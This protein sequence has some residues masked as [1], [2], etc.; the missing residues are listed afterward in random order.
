MRPEVHRKYAL[1][2]RRVKMRRLLHFGGLVVSK[3]EVLRTT[4]E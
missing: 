3:T 4:E 2:K 1:G